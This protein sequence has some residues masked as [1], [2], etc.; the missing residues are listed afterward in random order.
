MS[1]AHDRLQIHRKRK[2]AKRP[3]PGAS[4][5][6]LKTLKSPGILGLWRKI[7]TP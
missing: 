5:I 6:G 4:G 1:I 2:T 3:V 7:T